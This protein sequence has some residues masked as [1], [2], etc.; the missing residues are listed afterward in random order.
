M[1]QDNSQQNTNNNNN[2]NNK[3]KPQDMEVSS[4]SI[5][6]QEAATSQGPEMITVPRDQ[7]QTLLQINMKSFENTLNILDGLDKII[8][9]LIN[10]QGFV[11]NIKETIKRTQL[12]TNNN[13]QQQQEQPTEKPNA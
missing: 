10:M 7:Y 2:K 8:G 3:K 9:S 5:P 1:S 13:S 6:P 4:A 12:G 11:M